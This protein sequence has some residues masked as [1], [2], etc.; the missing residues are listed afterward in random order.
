M[1]V[2]RLVDYGQDPTYRDMNIEAGIRRARD[3]KFEWQFDLDLRSARVDLFWPERVTTP[4]RVEGLYQSTCFEVFIACQ[5][6]YLE[7]NFSPSLEWSGYAFSSYRSRVP[8]DGELFR[9]LLLD[10]SFNDGIGQ[11]SGTIDIEPPFAAI[12]VTVGQCELTA[13]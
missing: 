3:G 9:P 2:H 5:N 8:V 4:L 13:S 6:R 1:R 11:I 10:A 12:G 7:W